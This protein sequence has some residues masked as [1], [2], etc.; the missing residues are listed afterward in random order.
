M[1]GTT[2]IP[3]RATF[4]ARFLMAR[5]HV[6]PKDYGVDMSKDDFTDQMVDDFNEYT[7]GALSVDEML[8]RPKTA[9][10]FCDH[11]RQK[12]SYFD[13]PDDIVLR[14]ILTRRK[15]P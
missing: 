2:Q 11:V 7:K 8:L 12:Y 10:H 4:Y 9:L 6:K 1:M 5:Q 15:S 3:E 14:V 13:L